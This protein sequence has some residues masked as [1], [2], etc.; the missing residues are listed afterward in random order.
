MAMRSTT[1]VRELVTV[2]LEALPRPYGRHV[3]DEVFHTIEQ[4]ESWLKEYYRLAAVLGSPQR[5][6]IAVGQWVKNILR[7]PT[8]KQVRS[9]KNKLSPTYSILDAPSTQAPQQLAAEVGLPQ[10]GTCLSVAN[11]PGDT[12]DQLSVVLKPYNYK[13][14]QSLFGYAQRAHRRSEARCQLCGCGDAANFDM[15]RQMTIEHLIGQSQTGHIRKFKPLLAQR[16]SNLNQAQI[17]ELAMAVDDMNTVTACSFCNAMTSQVTTPKGMDRLITDS[18]SPGELLDLLG[19]VCR[20]LLKAKQ[21][22]VQRKLAAIRAA[23]DAGK[24]L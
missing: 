7:F 24:H 14:C 21:A 22:L 11:G 3:I 12:P 19:E 23:W 18:A 17:E 20:E 13:A 4:D 10:D 9:I 6:K 8:V 5:I 16:F 2:A 1:E 15:W